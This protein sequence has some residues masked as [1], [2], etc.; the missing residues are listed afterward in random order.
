[1]IKTPPLPKVKPSA[2]QSK[3]RLSVG[4]VGQFLLVYLQSVQKLVIRHC[5]ANAGELAQACGVLGGSTR[6]VTPLCLY[7]RP[8]FTLR[9]P[10]RHTLLLNQIMRK[11]IQSSTVSP[12]PARLNKIPRAILVEY[13]HNRKQPLVK[14]LKARTSTSDIL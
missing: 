12:I 5:G 11:L 7:R 14:S 8:A 1:V 4:R 10:D 13:F 3:P 6:P 9:I 2:D